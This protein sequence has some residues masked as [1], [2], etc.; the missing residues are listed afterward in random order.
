MFTAEELDNQKQQIIAEINTA[1]ISDLDLQRL[2]DARI[3]DSS[4]LKSKSSEI[5]NNI[6]KKY[7]K[8][9]IIT[10]TDIELKVFEGKLIIC[11]DMS[12]FVPAKD[13]FHV[14]DVT[15]YSGLFKYH[16]L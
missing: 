12:G 3:V 1:L 5:V 16:S 11:F 15:R 2:I 10:I 7:S 13:V 14:Y 8:S 6:L 9:I 4:A